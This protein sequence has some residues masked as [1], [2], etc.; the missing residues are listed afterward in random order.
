MTFQLLLIYYDVIIAQNMQ[1]LSGLT[2]SSQE[3]V[4]PVQL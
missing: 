3:S 4:K 1:I 2:V